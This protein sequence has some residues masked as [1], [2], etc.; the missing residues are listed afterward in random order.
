MHAKQV[1]PHGGIPQP[2]ALQVSFMA[3][4]NGE[5]HLLASRGK[6]EAED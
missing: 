3:R 6:L 5:T 2:A 1:L 4:M